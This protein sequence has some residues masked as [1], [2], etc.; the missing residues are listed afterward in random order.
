MCRETSVALSVS[1]R[2]ED[3]M[4]AAIS[5][6]KRGVEIDCSD[7]RNGEQW[8]FEQEHVA[9]RDE[10]VGDVGGQRSNEVGCV[11]V[12]R[13]EDRRSPCTSRVHETGKASGGPRVG[14][15]PLC[16]R[17]IHHPDQFAGRVEQRSEEPVTEYAL[18]V[19]KEDDAQPRTYQRF[20]PSG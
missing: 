20:T 4:L 12:G 2:P 8:R 13:L 9:G 1:Q 6:Q 7:A 3:R 10:Q 5:G 11:G 14:G 18:R 15:L 16:R 19:A 17:H